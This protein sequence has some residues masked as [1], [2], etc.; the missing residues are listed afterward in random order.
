MY[1]NMHIYTYKYTAYFVSVHFLCIYV[2]MY[3]YTQVGHGML[4]A[5]VWYE[6]FVPEEPQVVHKGG[7]RVGKF[8]EAF[9]EDH[10]H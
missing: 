5:S 2:Y 4:R 6:K 10:N 3:T 1:T 8:F 9:G 7:F